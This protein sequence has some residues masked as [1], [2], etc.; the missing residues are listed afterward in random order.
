MKRSNAEKCHA[1]WGNTY[2]VGEANALVLSFDSK[3]QETSINSKETDFQNHLF[4]SC[5]FLGFTAIAFEVVNS[6]I[7]SN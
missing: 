1:S 3:V 2:T 7:N 4:L 6:N 5:F